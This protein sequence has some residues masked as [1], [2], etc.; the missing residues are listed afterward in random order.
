ML[1]CL[2]RFSNLYKQNSNLY[3]KIKPVAVKCLNPLWTTLK[4]CLS[5]ILSEIVGYYLLYLMMLCFY[6]H[7]F[8]FFILVIEQL[9]IELKE[10]FTEMREMDLQIESKL[11]KIQLHFMLKALNIHFVEANLY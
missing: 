3:K 4:E 8:V 10:R 5:W 11:Q 9:P 6:I 1:T 7:I 2:A